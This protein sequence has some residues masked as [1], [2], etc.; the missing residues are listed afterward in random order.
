MIEWYRIVHSS[1]CFF[2]WAWLI[3]DLVLG[4]V[5]LLLNELEDLEKEN[6]EI[7]TLNSQLKICIR[8]LKYV[9]SLPTAL[10]TRL[11]K[12]HPKSAYAHSSITMQIDFPVLQFPMLGY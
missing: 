1:C 7:K 2:D 6:D 10:G 8:G 12:P 4:V 9:T 11:L 3:P 5:W